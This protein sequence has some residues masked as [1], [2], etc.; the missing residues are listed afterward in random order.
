MQYKIYIGSW[1]SQRKSHLT[2]F[3][4]IEKIFKCKNGDISGFCFSINMKRST[5]LKPYTCANS[6]FDNCTGICQDGGTSGK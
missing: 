2:G 4:K 1:Q 5:L 6:H 3:Y